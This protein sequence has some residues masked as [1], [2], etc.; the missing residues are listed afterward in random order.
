MKLF[1]K[2]RCLNAVKA[3]IFM[4]G[5]AGIMILL[6]NF[7]TPKRKQVYDVV[8]LEKMMDLYVSEK[9]NSIDVLFIGDSEAYATFCP[10]VMYSK[11]GFTSY[12]GGV[13]A[14]RLCDTYAFMQ[15]VFKT[16]SPKVVIMETNNLYR[17]AGAETDAD[18]FYQKF[19]QKVFPILKYH[20]RWKTY[21]I[22]TMNKKNDFEAQAQQKG[23]RFR[24]TTKPYKKGE[25]MIPS[26]NVEQFAAE[27]ENY[28]AKIR[29][30]CDENGVEF[31]LVSAPSAVCWN[32]ARHNAV[33]Q[34]ATQNGITFCDL[35]LMTDKLGIDWM[36]DTKDA[37]N[38]LNYIGAVKVSE[39]LADYLVEKYEL[40]DHRDDPD[41]DDWKQL[42]EDF[43]T[44]ANH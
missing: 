9:E 25:Y 18:N 33:E 28:L 31:M 16:Q 2:D 26:Q 17:Y 12:V 37:G 20:S 36:K 3:L 11:V 14:Q 44:M 13:S 35:N 6:S 4:G 39:Y 32:Y 15:D 22:A 43:F 24:N 1:T 19:T 34:Y 42:C 7:L 41:Y 40:A 8:S 30:L 10:M 5:L 38:H 29:T 27:A 23:F 21:C